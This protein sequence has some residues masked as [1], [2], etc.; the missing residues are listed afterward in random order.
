[1][2]WRHFDIVIR[3]SLL[4]LGIC[5]QFA[6]VTSCTSSL[7]LF[8]INDLSSAYYILASHSIVLGRNRTELDHFSILLS[9]PSECTVVECLK[10]FSSLLS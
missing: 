6:R 7:P 8:G 4:R 2:R 5:T 9:A 1:M 3:P 10:Y